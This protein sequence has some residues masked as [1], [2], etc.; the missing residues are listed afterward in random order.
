LNA[1]DSTR[2][3]PKILKLPL[4]GSGYFK[5]LTPYPTKY[6]TWSFY[7]DKI[8]PNA[9]IISDS[10]L[11]INGATS[12]NGGYYICRDKLTKFGRF[13]TTGLLTV[14]GKYINNCL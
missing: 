14:Y 3:H 4:G 2:I 6:I 8:P 7:E 9:R 5:C 10:T 12:S 13:I 1:L 11:Y